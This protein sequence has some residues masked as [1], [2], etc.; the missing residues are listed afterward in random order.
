MTAR[1]GGVSRTAAGARAVWLVGVC[2]VLGGL[3]VPAAVSGQEPAVGDVE[4]RVVARRTADGRVEFGLQQRQP[5]DTWGK[6]QLPSRRFFPTSAAVGRWLQ[7]SPVSLSAPQPHGLLVR[8]VARRAADGRVEFGLRQR[9]PDDTWGETQLPSRRFFPTSAAIGRWLQSS[10]VTITAA[11]PAGEASAAPTNPDADRPAREFVSVSVGGDGFACGLVADGSVHC[12]GRGAGAVSPKGGFSSLSAGVFAVCGI[13]A[14]GEIHCW[15]AERMGLLSPPAGG[16]TSVSVGFDSSCGLRLD[17]QLAC[18]G[19]GAPGWSMP[20]GGFVA[21]SAYERGAACGLRTGGEVTCWGDESDRWTRPDGP[22]ESVDLTADYACGVRP[23]GKMTCW[24][25]ANNLRENSYHEQDVP[26]AGVFVDSAVSDHFACGLRDGGEVACWGSAAPPMCE[27]WRT[28]REFG[29]NGIPPGP[30][31]SIDAAPGHR[32]G[33]SW[34]VSTVCGVRPDGRI[35][36]WGN[37]PPALRAPAGRFTAV[38]AGTPPCAVSAGAKAVCWGPHELVDRLGAPP[39]GAFT[40][41]SASDMHACGLRPDGTATCWGSNTWGA[42]APPPGRFTAID[43]DDYLSCGIR[44]DGEAA[45][46]GIPLEGEAPSGPFT[47]IFV[48][49]AGRPPWRSALACAQRPDGTAECWGSQGMLAGS[50]P[51]SQFTV[52]DFDAPP[53]AGSHP[54]GRF[55][56]ISV[57]GSLACGIRPGGAL[58]CWTPYSGPALGAPDP[59]TAIDAPS[60]RIDPARRGLPDGLDWVQGD[61]A[62]GPYVSLASGWYHTCGLRAHGAVDCWG[63]TIGSPDGHYTAVAVG[64]SWGAGIRSDGKAERWLL[65]TVADRGDAY[66]AEPHPWLDAPP[67]ARFIAVEERYA[68]A[69]GLL[70]TG[71]ITCSADGFFLI[72]L[73][74]HPG[75]FKRFSLGAGY[76]SGTAGQS[77]IG[78]HVCAIRNDGGIECWGAGTNDYGQTAL[79]APWLGIAPYSDVAAGYRHT[80]AIGDGDRVVC[81]GDDRYDQ[82]QSPPGAFG[83]LSAGFWHT[84]GLRTGGEITCW[85]NGAA[86]ENRSYH[87]PPTDR[88]TTPPPGPYTAVVAGAWHTCGLRSDGTATCWLSY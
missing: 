68:S 79:P 64:G 73:D 30:F 11:V 85:G 66:V 48:R 27:V 37:R 59:H 34:P 32:Q 36:C 47:A 31:T 8:V 1:D 6:T 86:G 22:V 62:G 50:S 51:E 41:V 23:S 24:S 56:T 76:I 42:A 12:W 20:D 80:C 82:T 88:P 72:S 54:G 38:H 21:V 35:A 3:L 63:P 75:P 49:A 39:D 9:Q 52:P 45:C 18:W 81:W 84:C 14:G 61:I 25:H 40:A 17:G 58:E 7:S 46:W 69:C 10:P 43:V 87:A 83:A 5:D 74:S 70:D 57:S 44:A 2:A 16:F 53:W 4:V 28:C 55:A 78:A 15:G 29:D 67:G 13:G 60:D 65:S 71:G 19:D 77:D 33:S 26:P